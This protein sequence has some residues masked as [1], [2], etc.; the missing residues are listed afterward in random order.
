MGKEVV[1]L[2]Q[3]SPIFTSF[4]PSSQTHRFTEKNHKT[5]YTKAYF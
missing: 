3:T 5:F 1:G 2:T 4:G